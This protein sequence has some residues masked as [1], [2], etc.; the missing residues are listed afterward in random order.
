[1]GGG[2]L[3]AA[4]PAPTPP[5]PE[6]VVMLRR[7]ADPASLAGEIAALLAAAPLRHMETPGGRRMSVA[8]SSCGACG[9]V[10][11]RRGY[12]YADC[13]PLSGAPWPAMPRAFAA[14]TEAAAKAA[15]FPGFAPDSCLINRYAPGARMALHQD[16]NERDERQPIV[17]V[18]LGLP[19]RFLFGGARR[20]DA[21][22]RLRLESGDVVVWGG[23]A[24]LFFHGVAPLAAGD[25]ALFG[26]CRF[27][28]TFRRAR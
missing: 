28:L 5:L 26:A 12:R 1:M 25:D 22:Q 14:L 21:A 20:E 10:S 23:P 7:F 19:A 17:S 6:G 13:D 15:G 9:W 16:R 4:L 27:N 18:S 8:M 24:R 2:D 11:D 3:L